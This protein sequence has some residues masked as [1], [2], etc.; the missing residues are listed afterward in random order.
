[1]T[2]ES[3]RS[4]VTDPMLRAYCLTNQP[5]ETQ[6]QIDLREETAKHH[7]YH[8]MQILPEQGHLLAWLIRLLDCKAVLELGVFTGYSALVMAQALPKD[9]TL[10]ACDINAEWTKMA[11]PFWQ[12]A[13]V[14]DQIDLRIGPASETLD[15]LIK[16]GHV[17][18]F[19]LIFID[20]DKRGY[21]NYYEQ[22]LVLL[23]PGG[24]MIL[25]NIFINGRIL[26]E[27]GEES[28][29][30]LMRSLNKKIKDDNR[31]DHVIIPIADGM[32]MIRK[33]GVC[34]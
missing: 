31:V 17:D 12:R 19:D 22:A 28:T 1:M 9:G 7:P 29:P 26:N 6:E 23:K 33:S 13:G 27:G 21:G 8:A 5:N 30:V 2:N 10:I 24:V 32:S 3:N 34:Y 15:Q 14:R 16:Q 11:E 4:P 18:T 20:A 25:D